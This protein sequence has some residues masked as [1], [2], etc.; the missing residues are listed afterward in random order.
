MILHY[1]LDDKTLQ[2]I[3]LSIQNTGT[4]IEN[5]H[6]SFEDAKKLGDEYGDLMVAPSLSDEQEKRMDEILFLATIHESV[7]F[8]V[9]RAACDR[10]ADIGLLSPQMLA[11]YEDQRAILRERI[12]LDEPLQPNAEIVLNQQI[13]KAREEA[14]HKIYSAVDKIDDGVE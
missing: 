12:D 2:H 13:Q 8:W 10:G 14:I 5:A 1:S 3:A 6:F 4:P 11:H 7:D 9:A